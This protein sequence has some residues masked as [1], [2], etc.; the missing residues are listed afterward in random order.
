[1]I[2][3]I[4]KMRTFYAVKPRLLANNYIMLVIMFMFVLISIG[5]MICYSNQDMKSFIYKLS[6]PLL[7]YHNDKDPLDEYRQIHESIINGKSTTRITFNG[8]TPAGYG[9][10][11]YSLLTSM[12]I[13]ILTDSA[14]IIRWKDIDKYVQEPFNQSFHN[15]ENEQS[16][17]NANHEKSSLIV[18]SN[19][20]HAWN[21][22]R[23]KDM[24]LISKTQVP[25]Y[26]NS[27]STPFRVFYNDIR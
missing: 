6:S 10:K 15:F 7:S 9:N 13:A 26:N 21:E 12:V 4:E 23:D 20:G 22:E 1:M 17:F 2:N 27:S 24:I 11:I 19:S 3:L 14:L 18:P 16:F 5:W 8:F 25:Y